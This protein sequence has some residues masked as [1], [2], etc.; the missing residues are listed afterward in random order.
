M[1]IYRST[2]MHDLYVGDEAVVRTERFSLGGGK[3]KG[4]RQAVNRVARNGYTISFH[5]PA[6]VGAD[7]GC[8]SWKR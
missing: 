5:D 8:A 4:L 6:H 7:A 3:F 2:G 1:P